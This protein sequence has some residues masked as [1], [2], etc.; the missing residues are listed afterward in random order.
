MQSYFSK[1]TGSKSGWAPAIQ[2]QQVVQAH[3]S[4]M[5]PVFKPS[6]NPLMFVHPLNQMQYQSLMNSAGCDHQQVGK[7]QK[8]MAY[9]TCESQQKLLTNSN[10]QFRQQESL[11]RLKQYQLLQSQYQAALVQIQTLKLQNSDLGKKLRLNKLKFQEL[12]NWY[13]MSLQS[14]EKKF[15]MLS[16]LHAGTSHQ[17]NTEQEK[18]NAL[19]VELEKSTKNL[20]N[21]QEKVKV[22]TAINAETKKTLH[23]ELLKY[24][25]LVNI[26]CSESKSSY[27]KDYVCQSLSKEGPKKLGFSDANL[28]NVAEVSLE[29]LS[30]TIAPINNNGANAMR[31]DPIIPPGFESST[32]T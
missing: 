20:Q 10:I 23:L 29:N 28:Q 3:P 19:S 18:F 31:N 16:R 5:Q 22:L 32:L 9:Q 14:E 11:R 15:D 30:R 1:P 7:A 13:M 21:E 2:L 24:K 25:K 27:R 8:T 12:N 6:Q 17:L 26:S 4:Q